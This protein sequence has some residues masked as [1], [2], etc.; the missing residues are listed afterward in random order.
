MCRCRYRNDPEYKSA[1]EKELI[2]LRRLEGL[3]RRLEGLEEDRRRAAGK[4]LGE[5]WSA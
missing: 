3:E 1:K 2:L 5:G 4:L